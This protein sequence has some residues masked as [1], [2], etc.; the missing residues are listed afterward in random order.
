VLDGHAVRGVELAV[1][2]PAAGQLEEVLVAELLD[3]PTQPRVGAEEVL[4]DVR[5]GLDGVLLELAVDGR[6][7]LVEQHTVDVACEQL[8]PVATP[9]HLD[10]V[11]PGSTERGLELLDDLAVAAHRAVEALQ[12]AVDDE[13]EVVEVLTRRDREAGGGLG[14]VHLAVADEAPDLRGTGVDDLVMEEVAVEARLGDRV[15]RPQPHR[16]GRELPEVG[17]PPRVRVAGEPA[18]EDLAAEA[19]E[20]LLGDATLEERPRVDPRCGVPLDED[21]VAEAAVVLPAPEVVEA[22]VVERRRGG[23]RR[24]V[25]TQAGEAVV[26]PVDHRHRVP[27]D[28][29]ADAL[30]DVL[31]RREPGLLVG[32]D[33]VD[34]VGRDHRGDVDPL[35]TRT[36]HEPRQQVAGT[37]AT[38]RAHDGVERVEP[39]L[40][41][42]RIDVRQLVHEAVEEHPTLR[43]RGYSAVT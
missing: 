13:D 28:V 31:V 30:L 34:V 10:D 35:V 41:L 25:A 12:V 17:E 1:V 39:L 32:R 40:G 42:G 18:A 14:L 9:D 22:D 16:H 26:R 8:V 23:E 19:V 36:L 7:H 43:L 11:P 33:R 38:V 29:G 5:A 15:Q 24:Q 21:L 37:G 3:H 2:V 6:V 27:A 20:L 4:A